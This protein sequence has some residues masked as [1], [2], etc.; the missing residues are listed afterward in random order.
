MTI[1]LSKL[2]LLED[3]FDDIQPAIK[4]IPYTENDLEEL[5]ESINMIITD[6][7]E[8]NIKSYKEVD[9]TND[10]YK[11]T[12]D[13][14]LQ[15]YN[16]IID[17]FEDFDLYQF[18]M[19]G[20]N[21]Y[22]N[23]IGIPRS[24]EKSI[25]INLPRKNMEQHIDMLRKIP[26]P[27]QRTDDWFEFRW[28]RITASSAWKILDTQ[29]N[30]NNFV[31]GKCKP[32][33]KA[34]YSKVNI[35]SATHHGHKYEEVSVII[36][37]NMYDTKI[38]E[39]GCIPSSNCKCIG[40]SPDGINVKKNNPRFGRLLE[41]KNPVSRKITG[42]PKKMYW[43]QM[44]IQMFVTQL[45]ECDFLETSFKSYQNEE[46]YLQDG[47]FQKTKDGKQKG[48]ITC[49]NDGIEPIYKYPPLN[50]TKE[51][52]DI[53]QDKT[54]EENHNLSWVYNTYWKLETIS[55][56]LVPYNKKWMDSVLPEFENMWNTIVKERVTGYSHRKPKKRKKKI[57]VT[58]ENLTEGTPTI[59]NI[60]TESLN[61]SQ[62]AS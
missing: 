42:I 30:I 50:I 45:Y 49:F 61:P 52:F 10:V 9:F 34:K 62:L 5:R 51:D 60:Q 23:L 28:N 35:N 41:I 39:F 56:V 38:E 29:A 16:N 21:I 13:V 33:D 58:K 20:I 59:L 19:E 57:I 26:Q 36:Y 53:W 32:I 7:V 48:I 12:Y 8:N 47:T 46:E 17:V 22:F 43:I 54:I 55:C 2:E 27:E 31:Y 44:Q 11:H 25:I 24:Y 15:L 18:V 1:T 14:I 3:I 6:F 40:A 37:E 4:I